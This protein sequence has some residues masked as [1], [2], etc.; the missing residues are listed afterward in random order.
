MKKLLALA[1][2]LTSLSAEA[3]TY[4]KTNALYWLGGLPNVQVET[5][6]AKHFTFQGEVN[7]SFWT[8]NDRPMQG[9]QFITGFRYYPS[10]KGAFNGFYLGGDF[11]F[12]VYKVS[13]WDHWGKSDGSIDIQ[14][15]I[16]YY[17]GFTLGY[18][19]PI[20]KRWNMDF[21]AGG[22]W[23]LGKYWGET[24]HQNGST[25]M[26]AAWNASGEWIPY[27]LGVTFGYRLT[28]EKRMVERFGENY[29]QP[30]AKRYK[31]SK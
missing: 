23:H 14:R 2:L 19:L 28:S 17:L 25:E 30:K 6:L 1:I 31:K 15:G 27:K 24:Q 22:G 8:I 20:A 9:A 12:D 11:A 4:I 13:K 18:Q 3:Q 10:K 29:Y 5:R 21:Y 26:Y 16:G 7:T